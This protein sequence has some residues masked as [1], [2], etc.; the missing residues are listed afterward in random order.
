M[1]VLALEIDLHLPDAMSLKAK[2]AVVKSLVEGARRRYGVSA[3]EVGFQER[4]QRTRLGFA[5]VAS[6]E[7]HA[8]EVLDQ[9][10]RFVWS[11]PEVQVLATE[12]RWLE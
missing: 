4:W 7:Y 5:V 12:R 10:D 6:S 1:Y 9:V 3:A 11:F 8:R 2:R